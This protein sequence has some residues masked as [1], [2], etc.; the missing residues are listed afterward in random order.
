MVAKTQEKNAF[1]E[2]G[3]TDII[4]I[5]TKNIL[6]VSPPLFF[7]FIIKIA[8][9]KR[10]KRRVHVPSSDPVFKH[11]WDSPQ[12]SVR[13]TDIHRTEIFTLMSS[14]VCLQTLIVNQCVNH[15]P[16]NR[17]AASLRS[18]HNDYTTF[19]SRSAVTRL[20]NTHLIEA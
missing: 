4:T 18:E 3:N 11:M 14:I 6:L 2:I 8:I 1:N 13:V 10:L 17:N 19:S 5:L 20:I 9:V 16:P 7:P 12:L 15:I